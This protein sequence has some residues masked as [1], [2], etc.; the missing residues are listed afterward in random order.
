MRPSPASGTL[1]VAQG[2]LAV[3]GLAQRVQH[4]PQGARAHGHVHDLT[5]AVHQVALQSNAAT[6]AVTRGRFSQDTPEP[7]T[8]TVATP[9]LRLR[10]GLP[11][12]TPSCRPCLVDGIVVTEHH[13]AHV[14]V[15]QV[16]RHA[17]DAAVEADQLAGLRV[18]GRPGVDR[19]QR[20]PNPFPAE[21]NA[22]LSAELS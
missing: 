12:R 22:E 18:G 16:E 10:T 7:S 13:H 14:V 2:A 1:T 15:L 9:T 5:C 4:T 20:T 11:Q 17:L 8:G 19:P 6:A 3:D 21:L